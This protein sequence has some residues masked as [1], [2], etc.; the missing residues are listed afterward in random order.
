MPYATSSRATRVP[1]ISDWPEEMHLQ[2]A[3]EAAAVTPVDRARIKASNADA[4]ALWTRCAKSYP[5]SYR[6]LWPRISRL[7][8]EITAAGGKVN[9]NYSIRNSV[10]A[11]VP[12]I[13]A[14]RA[15]AESSGFTH[16][17]GPTE[18]SL[19]GRE[20]TQHLGGL[21]LDSGLRRRH[22]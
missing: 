12:G 8:S 16:R 4:D 22:L 6:P 14:Y 13:G 9:Y 20:R 5:V 3:Q 2:A 11:R 19:D 18:H 1:G 10:A 17:Y 7:A 15:V 21:I